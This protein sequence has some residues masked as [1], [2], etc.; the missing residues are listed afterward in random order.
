MMMNLNLQTRNS[1]ISELAFNVSAVHFV[2]FNTVPHLD[3]PERR[4]AIT[5]S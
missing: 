4:S 2:S 5:Y 3:R 1:A